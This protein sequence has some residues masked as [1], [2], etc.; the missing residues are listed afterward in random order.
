MKYIK[1]F[2]NE[3]DYNS[4]ISTVD[5]ETPNVSIILDTKDIKYNPRLAPLQYLTI[6]SLEDELTVQLSNSNCQYSLDCK[7]WIDLPANTE[8]PKIKSGEKLY[9]KKETQTVSSIGTFTI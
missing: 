4:F 3:N 7:T 2:K 5:Y 6:E 1:I 8:T 9:F